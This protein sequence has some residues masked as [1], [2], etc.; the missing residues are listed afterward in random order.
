MKISIRHSFCKLEFEENEKY[1]G[2]T[3][4]IDGEKGG[5]NEFF[6]RKSLLHKMGWLNP[7]DTNPT[8]CVCVDEAIREDVLA[9]I[10]QVAENTEYSLV[11]W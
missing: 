8:H 7:T 1:C 4:F 6:I 11:L 5:E 3:L 2:R 9:Y 10:L